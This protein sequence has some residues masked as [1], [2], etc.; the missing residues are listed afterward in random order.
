MNTEKI[1]VIVPAFNLEECLPRCLDSIL[2]QTCKNLE[3]IVVDDGSR[4]NTFAVMEAYAQK[5]SRVKAI[6]KENGG[7]TSARLRGIAEATGEWLG[8]VDGD[9]EI[10]PQM[11]ERLLENAKNH[12]ADISHCGYQQIHANGTVEYH[13]NSGKL[14]HQD[15]IT[16]LRDLLE[17]RLVTTGLWN[18]LYKKELFPGLEE[19]MDW[20]IRINEDMLMNYYLF[21]GAEYSVYEDI[22]PY[23]YILRDDSASRRKLNEH[24]IYD[25]IR[26]REIILEQCEPELKEDARQALLRVL[27]Y[28]YALLTV[29]TESG[30]IPHRRAVRN[31]ICEQKQ[32]R[33]CLTRRNQ[34]LMAMIMYVPWAFHG[35]FKAYV[36][37]ARNGHYE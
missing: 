27:L 15:S 10:E 8:F 11:Y 28:V 31:K 3:I 14:H 30:Y 20:S 9:D 35:A 4:D 19:K 36:R 5:D 16:G 12:G 21:S 13:F 6:H 22:C 33:S 34:I 23:H 1:S 32:Y 25:P 37:I 26:V 7:V 29:E 24:R 2:A 18:K 17:E